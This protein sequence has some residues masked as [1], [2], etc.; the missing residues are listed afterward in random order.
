MEIQ[1]KK[2]KITF[3]EIDKE[4][5]MDRNQTTKDKKKLK[6]TDTEKVNNTNISRQ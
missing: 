6:K 5:V 3:R 2:Q 4:E 1:Q